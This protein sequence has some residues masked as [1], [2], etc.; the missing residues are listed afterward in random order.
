MFIIQIIII[1]VIFQHNAQSASQ[2]KEWGGDKTQLCNVN[3]YGVKEKKRKEK[4]CRHMVTFKVKFGSPCL[5]FVCSFVLFFPC[6][7]LKPT[8]RARMA[9][10]H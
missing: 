5:F 8:Y 9:L 4:G 1:K 7:S 2:H 6:K 10:N 3:K